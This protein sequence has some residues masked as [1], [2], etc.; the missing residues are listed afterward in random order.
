HLILTSCIYFEAVDVV[1]QLPGRLLDLDGRLLDE[2]QH[3]TE[4]RVHVRKPAQSL[5]GTTHTRM[6]T[7]VLALIQLMQGSLGRLCEP[8]SIGESSAL[9]DERAHF[10]ILQMQCSQ[11]VDLVP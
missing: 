2:T 3:G 11:L 6:R 5:E 8:P 9:L 4:L 1:L 7:A 10:A